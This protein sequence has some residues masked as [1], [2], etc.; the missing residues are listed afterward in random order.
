MI[1]C[2][3]PEAPPADDAGRGLRTDRGFREGRGN[4]RDTRVDRATPAPQAVTAGEAQ[5]AGLAHD[6]PPAAPIPDTLA[7]KAE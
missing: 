6:G 2:R 1:F 7:P 5:P 3:W 4:G